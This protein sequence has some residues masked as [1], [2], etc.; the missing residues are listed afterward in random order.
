MAL[1]RSDESY[2]SSGTRDLD[3]EAIVRSIERSNSFP[4]C[5][6][7]QCLDRRCFLESSR[8]FQKLNYRF[9]SSKTVKEM[10][11]WEKNSTV[12]FLKDQLSWN[13]VALSTI[14]TVQNQYREEK[15][16]NYGGERRRGR[17]HS[18]KRNTVCG[19]ER[20]QRR[21]RGARNIIAWLAR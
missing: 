8:Y 2:V 14:Q 20:G 19:R 16:K 18:L 7:S 13:S 9:K 21:Y 3:V 11:T 15:R 12:V 5:K 10:I 4:T 1:R 17:K 6:E